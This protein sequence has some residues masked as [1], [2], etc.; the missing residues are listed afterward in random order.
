MSGAPFLH[1]FNPSK[2]HTMNTI[3]PCHTRRRIVSRLRAHFTNWWPM[4][5]VVV[6]SVAAV[7]CGNG[8]GEPPVLATAANSTAVPDAAFADTGYFPRQYPDPVGDIE[9]LPAQF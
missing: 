1:F 3:I 6:M 2:D 7:G 8:D 4:S 5:I 9:P